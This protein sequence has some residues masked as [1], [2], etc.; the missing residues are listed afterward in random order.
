MDIELVPAYGRDYKSRKAVEADWYAGKD[1]RGFYGYC[2][3]RDFTG[4]K[5]ILLRYD[6]KLKVTVVHG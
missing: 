4:M 6:R 3:I 5:G 2:S 1:F